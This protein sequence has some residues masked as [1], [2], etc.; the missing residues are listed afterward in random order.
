[1]DSK[2]KIRDVV[3]GQVLAVR[4]AILAQRVQK[5]GSEEKLLKTYMG[6]DTKRMLREGQ[7]VAQIR[8][9][10]GVNTADLPTEA[11]LANTVKTIV[12]TKARAVATKKVVSH[13]Q[14]KEDNSN[15]NLEEAPADVKEM[16]T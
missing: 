4:P 6:R 9:A 15:D 14:P 1:M 12:A 16:L 10:L 8:K 2:T 3:T 11:E 13:K 5:A 7:T